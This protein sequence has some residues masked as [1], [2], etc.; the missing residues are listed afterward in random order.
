MSKRLP[1]QGRSP[2][3]DN[4][5]RNTRR[6]LQKTSL[7][8]VIKK[9]SGGRIPRKRMKHVHQVERQHYMDLLVK[10]AHQMY[11]EHNQEK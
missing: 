9:N 4:A 8:L 3:N 7:E 2:F 11:K 5:K 6:W 1:S 10:V